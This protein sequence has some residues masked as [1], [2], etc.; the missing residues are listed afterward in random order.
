V[1]ELAANGRDAIAALHARLLRDRGLQFD[2]PRGPSS[3]LR[4]PFTEPEWMAALGRFLATAFK[5]AL[6]V[7]EVVFK[8]G[9]VVAVAA[10]IF[11]ILREVAGVRFARRRRPPTRRPTPAD[12]RPE[13]WKAKALLEDADRLAAAGAYDEAAHLI[14]YRSIEDIEGRRPRLLRPAL[15]ARDIAALESL[16]GPARAAFAAIAARVEASYFGGRRLGSE[17]FAECRRSYERFAFAENW[18]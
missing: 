9:V 11:L 8:V 15:T 2:L 13:A 17:A 6:P 4:K 14:L 12:W 16:P 7:L 1:V 10:V 18:T 5:Q 3:Q